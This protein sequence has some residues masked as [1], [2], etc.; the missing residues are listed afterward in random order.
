MW[1]CGLTSRFKVPGYRGSC[2][3]LD[4]RSSCAVP[5]VSPGESGPAVKAQR[6]VA[7]TKENTADTC[8]PW[9]RWRAGTSR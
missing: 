5:P 3:P 6:L 2:L 8:G 9:T 4:F 7:Q 1:F